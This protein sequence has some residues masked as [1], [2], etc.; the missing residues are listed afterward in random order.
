MVVGNTEG[1]TELGEQDGTTEG[2]TVDSTDG[3]VVGEQVGT[4]E[5]I[6]VDSTDGEVLGEQ[7]GTFE[8]MTVDSTDGKELGEQDGSTVGEDGKAV[9]LIEGS[10]VSVLILQQ[11]KVYFPT[12]TQLQQNKTQLEYT[13]ELRA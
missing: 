13:N 11:V 7:D 5:G 9:G 10:M 6:T 8:G 3:E 1:K 12:S 4:I 2:I